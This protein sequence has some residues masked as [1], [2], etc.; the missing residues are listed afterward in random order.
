MYATLLRTA[1]VLLLAVLLATG[2]GSEGRDIDEARSCLEGLGLTVDAPA[3]SDKDVEEGLFATSDFKQ[4]GE[5]EFT[6]A[7]AAHV[8]NEAAVKRFQEESREFTESVTEDDKLE[9]ETG[10]DGSYV[11]VA[12]GSA[13][14]DA[15]AEARACVEA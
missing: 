13:D 15:V 11:W 9:I 7:M 2:C 14:S 8:R 5:G 3:E 4:A 12:G 1:S 10:T 6:F